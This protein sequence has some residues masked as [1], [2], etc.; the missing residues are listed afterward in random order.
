MKLFLAFI[1]YIVR[2]KRSVFEADKKLSVV[3]AERKML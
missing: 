2:N 1:V 3:D